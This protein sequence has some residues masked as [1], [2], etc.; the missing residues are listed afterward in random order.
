M[1]GFARHIADRTDAHLVLAGPAA[2]SVADDPEGAAV[3]GLVR[4]AWHQLPVTIQGRVHVASLPMTDI[5]ENAAIVNA[6]QRRAAVVVQKSIAEGFGLTVAEAMW[7]ERAVVAGGGWGA[8]RT[9]SSTGNR[10]FCCQTRAI[11]RRSVTRLWSCWRIANG[12]NGWASRHARGSG[13]SSWRH[14]IWAASSN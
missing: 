12:Q 8:S 9:R 11:S 7:K 5:G 10:A 3:I 6:L 13:T 14:A 2:D 4:D 1:A